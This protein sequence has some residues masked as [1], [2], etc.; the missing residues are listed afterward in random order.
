MSASIA[1]PT[2]TVV[3]RKAASRNQANVNRKA[4]QTC[5]AIDEGTGSINEARNVRTASS[6]GARWRDCTLRL[7]VTSHGQGDGWAWMIMDAATMMAKP[8]PQHTKP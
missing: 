8:I 4:N 1:L 2:L 3:T 6:G 5:R 7:K